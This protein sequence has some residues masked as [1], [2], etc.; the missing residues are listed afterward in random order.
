[1]HD[2]TM[3]KLVFEGAVMVISDVVEKIDANNATEV[4]D[5]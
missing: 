5:K 4:S 3:A 2:D 1:M